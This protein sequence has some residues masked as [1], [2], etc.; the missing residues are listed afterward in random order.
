MIDRLRSP[1]NRLYIAAVVGLLVI[2]VIVGCLV[3]SQL[4]KAPQET[5]PQQVLAPTALTTMTLEP[6][7]PAPAIILSTPVI[8]LTETPT[9]PIPQEIFISPTASGEPTGKLETTGSQ[10]CNYSSASLNNKLPPVPSGSWSPIEHY[11][12]DNGYWDIGKR[13]M[14]DRKTG[15][16]GQDGVPEKILVK[17]DSGGKIAD[18]IFIDPEGEQFSGPKH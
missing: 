1:E 5:T 16:W 11:F 2:A 6:T 13:D 18:R 12:C 14:V 9:L 17:Y 3:L 10:S 7:F 4:V 8:I 15:D